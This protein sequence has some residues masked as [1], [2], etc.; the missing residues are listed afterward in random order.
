M[1]IPPAPQ[2]AQT[3]DLLVGE[4]VAE[5]PRACGL[6]RMPCEPDFVKGLAFECAGT[7]IVVADMDMRIVEANTAYAALTGIAPEQLVGT[8]LPVA[9]PAAQATA[10]PGR[11][12]LVLQHGRGSRVQCRHRGGHTRTLWMNLTAVTDAAGEVQCHVATFTDV[13]ALDAE[14]DKLRHWAQHDPLTDLSNR[15]LFDDQLARSIARAQRHAQ[16]LALLFMDLDHFKW[17]NDT[18]GH[19]AG[20]AVLQEVARRLRMAVRAED[21][22]ARWG[23]DEFI[24]VLSDLTQPVDVEATVRQLQRAMSHPVEISGHQLKVSASIGVAGFPDD[25]A[26]AEELIRL[27]DQAMYQAKRRGPGHVAFCGQQRHNGHQRCDGQA[28]QGQAWDGA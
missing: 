23:G 13:A 22:T 5:R 21:L 24:V 27:A 19:D 14:M 9:K 6:Q 28:H 17:I 15:R 4:Q 7:A 10:A 16:Y 12:A 8:L 3:A 26:N 11:P 1:P 20:D 18:L 25:A 2:L